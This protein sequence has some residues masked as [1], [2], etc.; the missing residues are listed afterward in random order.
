ENMDNTET[1]DQRNILINRLQR[2]KYCDNK[3][4]TAKYNI[5]TFI[6]KSLWEQFQ[7]YSNCFFLFIVILQQIP[8]VS[9]TGRFTTAVPLTFILLVS[10]I[11]QLLEDY[12]L[13]KSD[14]EVNNSLIYGKI[15]NNKIKN[16][17]YLLAFR[18]GMWIKVKWKEL[19]VG[20]LVKVSEDNRFPAD[21]VLLASSEPE[22]MCYIQTS[23]LDGE[24]NLK[25][26][27][28]PPAKTLTPQ[29]GQT[30]D[31]EKWKSDITSKSSLR[32]VATNAYAGFIASL[33]TIRGKIEC[34]KPTRFLYDF[35]GSL[36]IEGAEPF[37][38][39]SDQLLLR[40]S[41]LKNT[42]WIIGVCVYTGHETKIML[43]AMLP[44][45]KRSSIDKIVN[46][47][48][49]ILFVILI[50]LCL[51]S[52]LGNTIYN[53]KRLD[54]DWYLGF[55]QMVASNFGYIFLT[56][57]ILYNNLIP[58]SLQVT[59]EVI[60]FFQAYFINVDADMY[61]KDSMTYATARTSSLN[62]ELGQIKYVFS[63][64]TGT[65]TRNEMEFKKCT[66]GGHVYGNRSEKD[67]VFDDPS[68]AEILRGS[69]EESKVV[70]QFMTVLAVCHTVIPMNKQNKLSTDSSFSPSLEDPSI[71]PRDEIDVAGA[72]IPPSPEPFNS[73]K[74]AINPAKKKK[75][76]DV[77]MGCIPTSSKRWLAICPELAPCF[78][79]SVE[80]D[81]SFL[82][83][84]GS[85][86][87]P[88]S[89]DSLTPEE[90]IFAD[91]AVKLGKKIENYQGSSPDECALVEGA[92]KLGYDFVHREGSSKV[93]VDILGKK[94][95]FE[96]LN[97]L[98]FNSDRKRMSCIIKCPLGFLDS[99]PPGSEQRN[100][101]S[102]S[103]GGNNGKITKGN[104]YQAIINS[105]ENN[106][107]LG[108][109]K[110]DADID[111]VQGK[112]ENYNSTLQ[113][114]DQVSNNYN[115]G[116]NGTDHGKNGDYELWLVTKGAD[117]EV[118]ARLGTDDKNIAYRDTTMN[119][120]E[121]FAMHGLRTLCIA[122]TP[123]DKSIYEKWNKEYQEAKLAIKDRDKKVDEVFAQVEKNL[124]LLGATAIE[125]KL[126]E[127]V[128]ECLTK[129]AQAGIKTWVLT[130][131]K[132]QTAINIGYSCALLTKDTPL[133]V[134]NE[135]NAE[136]VHN[137]LKRYKDQLG[138]RVRKDNRVAL[139]IDGKS[140]K[141][142]LDA[143]SK[144][145]FLDVILSCQTII[146][147]RTTPLQKSEVV[148]LIR[149]YTP[150]STLAIGDG[151]NDVAMIQAAHVGVGIGGR[152]GL[153]AANSSDFS[154]SQF[155]F[156]TKLL[157]VHGAWNHS[158]MCKLI[159]Y[160]F[161]K[162]ICMYVIE[163]W[164][165]MIS[166]FSGQ[167]LFER[168]TLGLYNVAF[169]VLPPAA[170]GLFDRTCSAESCLKFPMLYSEAFRCEQ[171]DVKVFWIW[172]MNAVLH[173]LSIFWFTFLMQ[174]N[175]VVWRSG[176]TG[177]YLVLGNF[178][179]TYVVIVVCLKSGLVTQSWTIMSQ[180][181]IWGSIIF[182]MLFLIV[183]SFIW[184]WIPIASEMC[185][186]VTLIYSSF[187]YWFGI[188][189]IPLITL[190]PDFVIK[191][192]QRTLCP[193]LI[194]KVRE[195]E[196][197][198]QDPTDLITKTT[199]KTIFWVLTKMFE[200][201]ALLDDQEDIKNGR[202]KGSTYSRRMSHLP[203]SLQNH[204]RKLSPIEKGIIAET[205]KCH[206][207]NKLLTPL[208]LE[209]M[210]NDHDK[211]NNLD[212]PSH[213]IYLDKN[214]LKNKE[215][216]IR[217]NGIKN[218]KNGLKAMGGIKLD[219]M[220]K[221]N[222]GPEPKSFDQ[223]LL[224]TP[225]PSKENLESPGVNSA[226]DGGDERKKLNVKNGDNVVINQ[227]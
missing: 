59:V 153:Q 141:F 160:Q 186:E 84:Q 156:L 45:L 113:K 30:E 32:S 144:N 180:I 89:N 125:D 37:P 199:K 4:I 135:N 137:I 148:Q 203:L 225:V 1:S 3:V 190:F 26:R 80:S 134:V 69:D 49:I 206:N 112:S 222:G 121:M 170:I 202:P 215:D 43:N 165:A 6:P 219:E 71:S 187:V 132:Q 60:R 213:S 114:T 174:M 159:L 48:I 11:K 191:V 128:P 57:V 204:L 5:F 143:D 194:E 10:M 138:D 211:L 205:E 164:F 139:I 133:L 64:K 105:D 188:I 223:L 99:P 93:V 65:L 111:G 168:W 87:S 85:P 42:K 63:D 145:D 120:L 70:R 61:D 17:L 38:L 86:G 72:N 110:H 47:Q 24:T 142:A 220:K 173:S 117:N 172:I 178:I 175:D 31:A 209:A 67:T 53:H 103:N 96:V 107:Q 101:T 22:G 193:S 78:R 56:F 218:G 212:Q 35:T 19:S 77:A 123:I 224:E 217:L 14:K 76:K 25:I 207:V 2:V 155:R 88:T 28:A 58:I 62:E 51:I 119:D 129:L 136:E 126:Q 95:D 15:I 150:Y 130:G 74:E 40:G 118:Y 198:N 29:S 50:S 124:Q 34:E 185:G 214:E 183:Y 73:S 226:I 18:H 108:Q 52:A 208:D 33:R 181:A 161:Y 171:F 21:L 131:D 82:T 102:A 176:K 81:P 36:R 169:T 158:R 94:Y 12:R 75:K 163:L 184:P 154:I 39:N 23:N 92:K 116:A 106:N 196:I 182:W 115:N 147:C 157:L 122:V 16:N 79:T 177:D 167:P 221:K 109:Q 97:I 162:N 90:D 201:L 98:D 91:V 216:I 197:S 189:I 227:K 8:G 9:P 54:K 195:L 192:F 100:S 140:L 151:S 152:E 46:R 7:I 41:Q 146:C 27:Q 44:S 66:I 179:Y 149:A 127:G 20:D 68:F 55:S 83:P 210:E 104:N 200:T 13:H 166:Y